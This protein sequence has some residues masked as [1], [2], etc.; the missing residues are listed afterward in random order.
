LP[1]LP[2]VF[3]AMVLNT[4]SPETKRKSRA[5]KVFTPPAER[6]STDVVERF[7]DQ[8]RRFRDTFECLRNTDPDS[9][10]VTSPVASFVVY[11]LRHAMLIVVRHGERHL[12]QAQAVVRAM[13]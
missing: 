12:N 9:V 1:I 11:S 8:Q 10:I 4:V 5:P 2:G 13:G 7:C 3:G 6:V